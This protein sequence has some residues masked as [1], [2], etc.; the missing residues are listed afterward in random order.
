MVNWIA[1]RWSE[2]WRCMVNHA[3]IFDTRPFAWSADIPS[4]VEAQ[5]GDWTRPEDFERFNPALHIEN[6]RVR[7]LVIHGA[8]DFRVPLEQG[9]AAHNAARRVGAPTELLVFPDENHWIL[10][11]QNS[12]QWYAAVQE[13]M[14]RWTAAP[15]ETPAASPPR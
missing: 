5:F 3:G 13:W 4:Y 1:G 11:P 15:G 12:V 2:P 14:D 8:R 9:I 7:M 6:W 10:K